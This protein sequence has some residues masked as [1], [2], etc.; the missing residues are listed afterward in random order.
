MTTAKNAVIGLIWE[1][2]FSGGGN[3]LLVKGGGGRLGAIKIWYGGDS[4]VENSS[5]LKVEMSKFFVGG[6]GTFHISPVGKTLESAMKWSKL[7]I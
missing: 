5:R 4:T 7:I 6:R 3:W 2:L 1:L